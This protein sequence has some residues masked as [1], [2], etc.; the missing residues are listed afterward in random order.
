[1]PTVTGDTADFSPLRLIML[2]LD[3][4]DAEDAS[5]SAHRR[6]RVLVRR[7]GRPVGVVDVPLE[8]GLLAPAE[9]EKIRTRFA[10]VRVPGPSDYAAG[11]PPVTVVIATH[12]RPSDLRRCLESVA[13]MG[14]PDFK[15]VVVDNA[16]SSDSTAVMVA[17]DFPEVSYVREDVPGLAQAH[18]RGL[19]LVTT[20][21]VAFTD[22]DVVVDRA[23][24][25]RLASHF[26][27]DPSVGCVTGLIWPAE[28]E[29]HPQALIDAHG[30]CSKGF[31]PRRFDLADDRPP[32]PL[33][34]YTAGQMGSGANMAF[35]LD[36][37]TA[38]GRF[39]PALG[40]GSVGRGGDDLAAF[41]DVVSA[42]YAVVY[43][44]AAVVHH[45]YR[46]EY[47]DLRAQARNYGVGLSAYLTRVVSRK[48][49]A[50]LD[51]VRLAPRGVRHLMQS[52]TYPP[53][54]PAASSHQLR[55]LQLLGMALG[56]IAYARSRWAVRA[57]LD[58]AGP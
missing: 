35:T 4:P 38:V 31:S 42:G 41:F 26:A 53:A 30:R 56:P 13:A 33:F 7:D 47:D 10:G 55:R 9:V 50:L 58:G 52:E 54:V 19:E 40:A 34:P 22:D 17:R 48:P 11:L 6:A 8:G 18:N 27:R 1:M 14:H 45:L 43:E 23:W 2:D 21:V 32:D 49:A 57:A 12:D 16:P 3:G 15:V 28:L 39:D 36:A 20:P 51:M 46:R 37:L 44:P 5:P 24:A 25:S 29:T